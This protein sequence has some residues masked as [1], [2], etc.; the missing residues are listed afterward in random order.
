[1]LISPW[2]DVTMTDLRQA[3]IEPDDPMLSRPG[4][5]EHGRLY[6]G[7]LDTTDYRVSPLRGDLRG[8]APITVLAA[9]RD[10][11]YTDGVNLVERAHAAGTPVD[12]HTGHNLF[13]GWPLFPSPE[14]RAARDLIVR[15]CRPPRPARR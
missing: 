7:E 13:H 15:A 1:M 11:L 4:L 5:V 8:V 6:A 3:T 2:L 12:L 10:I 9:D 14:G